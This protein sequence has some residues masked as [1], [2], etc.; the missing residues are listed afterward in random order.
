[1]VASPVTRRVIGLI[2][3]VGSL[4]FLAAA[5]GKTYDRLPRE[6][7]HVRPGYAVAAVLATVLGNAFSALVW[8]HVLRAWS[9]RLPLTRSLRI[10]SISQVMKYLPGGVWQPVGWL[11]LA[12]EARIGSGIA[13]ASILLVMALVVTGALVVGPVFL[14]V[15]GAGGWTGWLV[16]VVP[17]VLGTLHPAVFGRLLALAARLARKPALGVGGIPFAR[18]AGGLALSVPI[19][20]TYGLSLALC[21][22]AIRVDSGTSWVILTGAFAVA[23]AIGFLALP[24]PGGLG[25]RETMLL[26]L[27]DATMDTPRAIALSVASRLAFLLAEGGM[28]L[29]ALMA[30]R[31]EPEPN[32]A[33]SDRTSS[34]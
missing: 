25:V 22:R 5:L 2:L 16:L 26:V 6:T 32:R 10:L 13:G 20:L 17:V 14:A 24:V 8:Q 11:G 28:A 27:L 33:G 29:A 1:M 4:G 9:I 7:I 31:R 19:W 23:W 12:R 34:N 21:A 3:L 15:G 18:V 30:P